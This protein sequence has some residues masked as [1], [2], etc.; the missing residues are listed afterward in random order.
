MR[1]WRRRRP[2]NR[3]SSSGFVRRQ[4][5][6]RA[7]RSTAVVLALAALLGPGCAARPA[8]ATPTASPP[9]DAR[10]RLERDLQHLFGDATYDHAHLAV[11]VSSVST[12]DPLF[13]RHAGRLLLPAS[14]QKLLTAAAAAVRLG[15]EYRFTTRLVATGPIVDGTLEGDLVIVGNGDP[16][17]NPR[18]PARWRAFDDWAAALRAK[19]VRIIRGHVVGDDNAVAEPG[20]GLGWSWDDLSL[21]YGAPIGALQYNENQIEVIVGP[22]MAPGARAIVSTSPPGSGILVAPAV[23][24]AD[25]GAESRV[26]IAR[27]PGTSFLDVRGQVAADARPMSILAS[28]DNPTR[29]Y[30]NA[31]R[32]ALARYGIFVG[33][34]MLD[35]DEL[36][37]PPRL[38]AGVEL[39]ADRSPPLD[40][41]IDVTLKWSRNG[42]AE[43]LLYAMAPPGVPQ[44][45][46]QGLEAL[47]A[48]LGELGLARDAYLARDGSGLSRYDYLTA[49]TLVTLLTAMAKAPAHAERFRAALPVAGVSGNLA[50]RLKGTPAEGRVWAKT[51]SMSQVR[52]LA[53]YLTAQNGDVLA[54]ALLANN[55]RIPAAEIDALFDR[56][57]LRLIEFPGLT[58][59][60]LPSAPATGRGQ[61]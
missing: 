39:V 28:V 15:W 14:N 20:W 16:S 53:G 46:T 19:G 40:E 4:S 45:D 44:T 49:D 24:T 48:T 43:T 33:G 25:A 5:T 32:D 56:V 35:V 11:S 17:I 55:F 13:R 3:P 7:V 38:D 34:S 21:G 2:P 10:Q 18:H 47:R 30:L 22:G 50:N 52:T 27:R 1:P 54:F 60:P 31:F 23:T 41:I 37:A 58:A 29:L 61:H 51:G 6:I 57:L 42:Y 12:G 36:E 9:L 59:V 26:E 8:R